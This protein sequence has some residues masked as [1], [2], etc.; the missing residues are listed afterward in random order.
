MAKATNITKIAAASLATVAALLAVAGV[1]A[2]LLS[3][4]FSD[5]P[6]THEY[7]SEINAAHAMGLVD[8]IGE[9]LYD[10]EGI[11]TKKQA[12]RLV[13]NLLGRFTDANGDFELLRGEAALLSLQTYQYKGFII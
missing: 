8:G 7:A 4:P 10:P 9:G 1:T 3:S 5:V 6:D 2:A 11:L 12:T 13:E